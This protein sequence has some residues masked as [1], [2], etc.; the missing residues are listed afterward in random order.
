MK[1]FTGSKI[2]VLAL[3]LLS[4][5]LA[6]SCSKAPVDVQQNA[7]SP[8]GDERRETVIAHTTENQAP[9]APMPSNTG[10]KSKWTQGGEAIDTSKLDTAVIAAEKALKT[11]PADASAKQ[12]LAQAYLERALALTD[13]RQYASALGDYRRTLKYDPSNAEAKNWIEQIIAIYDSMNKE[14]PPE[15][16]EPPP[17]PYKG[18]SS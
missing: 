17:L 16:Q 18:A 10:P 7:N 6:A 1:N 11:K 9:S 12:A 13:A 3:A 15:G 5:G 2:A 8:R 4:V 14:S